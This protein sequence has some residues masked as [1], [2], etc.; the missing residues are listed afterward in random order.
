MFLPKHIREAYS[1]Y[2]FNFLFTNILTLISNCNKYID[3]SKPWALFKNGDQKEVEIILYVVL[4]SVRFSA[5][6]LAP[7]I[8]K[9]SNKIY[10]QLGYEFDFNN[11][12]LGS[13][14]PISEEHW[15]WGQLNINPNLPEAEP[16]FAKLQLDYDNNNKKP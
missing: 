13:K 3:D 12:E 5:F 10:H 15:Q 8:P 2:N 11:K 6:A 14:I 7:I 16:I 1:S 4:E 9:I